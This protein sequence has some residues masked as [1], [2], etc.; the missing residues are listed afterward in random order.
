[1]NDSP[2]LIYHYTSEQPKYKCH[3]EKSLLHDEEVC[4]NSEQSEYCRTMSIDKDK[5]NK[6]E[7]IDED[8]E[9]KN[10]YDFNFFHDFFCFS[11]DG[12]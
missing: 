10:E 8:K 7:I 9:S 6:G 12:F 11:S 1:M 5:Y 3:D 2:L 4:F